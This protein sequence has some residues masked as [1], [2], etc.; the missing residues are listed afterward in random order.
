MC[1]NT[2]LYSL[3]FVCV[4]YAREKLDVFHGDAK[5]FSDFDILNTEIA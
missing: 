4:M 1:Q 5:H 3:G 2:A